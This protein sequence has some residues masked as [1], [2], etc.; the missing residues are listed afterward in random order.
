[1]LGA[2]PCA[3]F[4]DQDLIFGQVGKWRG[5]GVVSHPPGSPP[6]NIGCRV[7][8]TTDA[9]GTMEIRGRCAVAAGSARLAIRL[10]AQADGTIA[11]GFASPQLS[12][13]IQFSGNAQN[14]LITLNTRAPF[15][16][17]GE[18][19]HFELRIAID[20]DMSFHLSETM[21]PLNQ[22]VDF[23]ILDLHFEF[24]GAGTLE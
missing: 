7:N 8:A 2:V 3:V 18:A 14:D 17:D 9:P 20:S 11:A 6:Q 22:S 24:Q 16:L 4:A 10:E 13:T 12:E 23:D 19:S 15:K 5:S 21:S 1:M